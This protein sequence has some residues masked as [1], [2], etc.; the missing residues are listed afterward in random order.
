MNNIKT[1][2]IKIG[3]IVQYIDKFSD[4]YM[5]RSDFHPESTIL[6]GEIIKPNNQLMIQELTWNHKGGRYVSNPTNADVSVLAI[7]GQRNTN[8][9]TNAV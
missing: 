7:I 5:L 8:Q 9:I 1:E 3:D 6:V 2:D 4:S